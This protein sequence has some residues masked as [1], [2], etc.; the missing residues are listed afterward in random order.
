M[1]FEVHSKNPKGHSYGP[2]AVSA[3]LCCYDGCARSAWLGSATT[4]IPQLVGAVFVAAPIE[5]RV[6]MLE[7]LL[8]PLGVLSLAAVAGGAFAKIRFR[9]GGPNFEIRADDAV[10]V[11]LADVVS[12]VEHVQQVDERVVDGLATLLQAWPQVRE[13]DTAAALIQLLRQRSR[14]NFCGDA[15]GPEPVWH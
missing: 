9:S 11:R 6:K 8:R 12:L 5:T 2:G 1:N 4:S 13:T 14:Q 10:S 7:H 3:D 15:R